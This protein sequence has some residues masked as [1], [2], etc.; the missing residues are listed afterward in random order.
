MGERQEAR[1]ERVR[2]SYSSSRAARLRPIM[3]PFSTEIIDTDCVTEDYMEPSRLIEER[4]SL[5]SSIRFVRYVC[6]RTPV[7]LH[8]RATYAK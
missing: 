7:R 5:E 6:C 2:P 4:K 3:S 1:G 8:K